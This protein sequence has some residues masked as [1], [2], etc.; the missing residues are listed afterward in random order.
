MN[1]KLPIL[2]N[3]LFR[4]PAYFGL[5]LLDRY[6][7]RSG[8]PFLG[9]P[10]YIPELFTPPDRIFRLL[11]EQN[12]I[13]PE[14]RF[15]SI[16]H[17]G[18]ADTE[19]D[20]NV[21]RLEIVYSLPMSR[22]EKMQVFVKLPTAREWPAIAKAMITAIFP[23]ANEIAFHNEVLP[24]LAR[25]AGGRENLGFAVPN[26]LFATLSRPFYRAILIQECVDMGK[27]HSRADWMNADA[28]MVQ[29]IIDSATD[30]HRRTW[31]LRNVPPNVLAQFQETSGVDWLDAGLAPLLLV[32][33]ASFRK[34]WK[35]IKK[36]TAGEPVTISHGDCRLGN[37]LFTS[38]FSEVLLTDW[39]VN[40]ITYYL[41]DISY[42][43][44]CS[45]TPEDRRK[46]EPEIIHRYLDAL[47]KN[48]AN[49]GVPSFEGAME[50]HRISLIV[51]NFFAGLIESFGGVGTKQ[52]NSENDM[53]SWREKCEAAMADALEDEAV[54]AKILDVPV[55]LVRLFREDYI[56]YAQRQIG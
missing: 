20:K 9:I 42:C 41:W 39:E 22:Q 10:R 55:S 12:C 24:W 54:L 51:I 27:Y 2:L 52:G 56:A 32:A 13:P 33:P 48:P 1:G 30:L 8:N 45:F 40:S 34:M 43:M 50:L 23:Y 15:V 7:F 49:T 53:K 4:T 16:E 14:A 26:N 31:Q 5:I 28:G 38:D 17:C 21:A 25:Q 44:I 46:Y 6:L 11:R 47:K 36:R 3:V 19:P 29:R 35:A 37:C 18:G